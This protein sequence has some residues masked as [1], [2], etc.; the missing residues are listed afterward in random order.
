MS[1]SYRVAVLA[2]GNSGEREISK[3]S[4][5]SVSEALQENGYDVTMLDPSRK[6]DLVALINGN[7]DV[8]FLCLHGK[9]GEDGA[10]QGLLELI[11]LPYTGSPIWSSAV[12]M[13]KTC[14]KRYFDDAGIPVLPSR[15]L[16]KGEEYSVEE[17]MV[18]CGH[19][20]VVKPNA[21]GSSIG[22]YFVQE[23]K[24]FQDAIEQ[25][26]AVSDSIMIERFVKGRELTVAVLGNEDPQVLPIIEIVPKNEFYDFESKYAPG[27]SEHICPAPLSDE[28]T[29]KVSDY[30][31]RAHKVLG[32]KGVS[33]TDFLLDE[34]G[35]PWIL[36]TNTIPGMTSTSLVPDAARAIGME[37][38]ELCSHLV[39]LALNK[40]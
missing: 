12:A 33:R 23:P 25:A 17:L 11:E 7:F 3:A 19:H 28:V 16:T 21:E 1:V 20:C 37:F 34:E 10:T 4:G 35:I 8:A 29:Q 30:A 9:N 18:N 27:G 2:G 14:A 24:E 36:E 26:F 22:I 13:D 15:L 6:E 5:A 32:C 39:K 38:P 40:E 31:K